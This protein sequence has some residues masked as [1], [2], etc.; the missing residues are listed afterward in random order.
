[1]SSTTYRCKA[2]SKSIIRKEDLRPHLYW[3][4]VNDPDVDKHFTQE[5]GQPAPVAEPVPE[6]SKGVMGWLRRK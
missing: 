4:G 6:K 5:Q 2:C 1:M 3:H